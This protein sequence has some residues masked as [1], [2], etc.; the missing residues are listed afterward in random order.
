MPGFDLLLSF[1]VKY[2]C[3]IKLQVVL[4]HYSIFWSKQAKFFAFHYFI[5]FS[6]SPLKNSLVCAADLKGTRN[7]YYM[8]N[9][10]ATGIHDFRV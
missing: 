7:F 2:N 6:V 5:G 4:F 8:E 3:H 10:Q 9:W 1:H